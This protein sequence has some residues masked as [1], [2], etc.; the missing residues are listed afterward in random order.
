MVDKDTMD[1]LV[2]GEVRE[3]AGAKAAGLVDAQGGATLA[4]M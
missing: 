4:G 3:E 1:R 2:S